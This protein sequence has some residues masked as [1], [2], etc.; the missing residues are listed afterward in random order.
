MEST[1]DFVKIEGNKIDRGV[2]SSG[3]YTYLTAMFLN[4]SATVTN[5]VF[6]N[7]DASA[8]MIDI[9]DCSCIVTNNKF[10]RNNTSI[11]YY[12]NATG[13]DHIVKNNFFDSTTVDGTSEKLCNFSSSSVYT[14]E[15]NKNQIIYTTVPL[16]GQ[17]LDKSTG[18]NFQ[19]NGN[20]TQPVV[21]AASDYVAIQIPNATDT[22]TEFF[23]N[24]SNIVP[25]GSKILSYKLGIKA[26]PGSVPIFNRSTITISESSAFTNVNLISVGTG[27]IL[28]PT[29]T[30]TYDTLTTTSYDLKTN[31]STV[32]LAPVYLTNT[33][34]YTNTENKSIKVKVRLDVK[35]TTNP[36]DPVA[37]TISPLVI[38]SVF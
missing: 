31:H 10:I 11:D 19:F 15:N 1:L 20:G 16:G 25:Y 22:Q 34:S 5:N 8:N 4:S 38:K 24:V 35:V 3:Y 28:D 7:T 37:Y 12:I 29:L 21:I 36:G 13:G 30:A 33:V 6:A 26:D 23:I 32:V 17:F 27:S 14:Y 2:Y 18:G 9:A